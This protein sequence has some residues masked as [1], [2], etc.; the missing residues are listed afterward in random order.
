M[1]K[2]RKVCKTCGSENVVSD[3]Y[4]SWNVETQDWD[5][6]ES[7]FDMEFCYDC[8][9]ETTVVDEEINEPERPETD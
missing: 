9:G 6:V 1:T 8:E 2:V 4:V 5:I 3:A 7:V